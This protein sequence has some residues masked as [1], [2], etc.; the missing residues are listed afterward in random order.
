MRDH[1]QSIGRLSSSSPKRNG[2]P[3]ASAHRLSG[4]NKAS[5]ASGK[6]PGPAPETGRVVAPTSDFEGFGSFS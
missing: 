2:R 5:A 3:A 6:T 4:L 1:S